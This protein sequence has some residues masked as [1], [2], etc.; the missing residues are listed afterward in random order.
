MID[1]ANIDELTKRLAELS[2]ELSDPATYASA[3]SAQL[4]HEQRD[5]Q[6]KLELF[7]QVLQT[8]RELRE[9][10]AL[11]GDADMAELAKA[12]IPTLESKLSELKA[13]V[14]VAL[15]P[16][17]PNDNKNAIIEIRAGAGGDESSLFAGEL[18]RMYARFCERHGLKID[19]MSE[20]A[21]TSGGYKELIAEVSGTEAYGVLKYESGV[22]R[23]QRIPATESAGRI[24]TSTVTVAVLPEAEEHDIEIEPSDLRIDVYRSSGNGGQSVNT[25]D[26][27]VRITHVPTNTVVTCQDEKSQLKNKLKA[28]SI[29]RSRLLAVQQEQE[30][31]QLGA[32]R[33]SQIGTGDRSEKIRTYNFPQDRVTDHRIGATRHN[34]VGF[35]DGEIDDM[36]SS[37]REA[38]ITKA[39]EKEV[40]PSS[41]PAA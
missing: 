22:H 8:E 12:E 15:V 36:L 33:L 4:V 24:H 26:S 6:S 38:D 23:V 31:K 3:R 14:R 25:T 9:A 5:L 34:L 2:T 1:Q 13:Q 18:A 29:L 30:Q 17:D 28:M 19:I 16:K 7:E 39:L 41:E 40:S 21:G 11:L 27:A 35:L 37:L 10:K 20:S 32:A